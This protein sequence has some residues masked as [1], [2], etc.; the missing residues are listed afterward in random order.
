MNILKKSI[1]FFVAFLVISISTMEAQKFI[2]WSPKIG[3]LASALDTELERQNEMNAETEGRIGWTI[4]FDAR[5]T[6]R[7]LIIHPGIHY[8]Q[9]T[10]ELRSLEEDNLPEILE[11]ETTISMLKAPVAIG[12]YLTGE[13][14]IVRLHVRGGIAAN[15]LLGVT[16][17][18][19]FSVSEE[20]L[21][22]ITLGAQVGAGLDVFFGTLDATY[23]WGLTQFFEDAEGKNNQFTISLGLVF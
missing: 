23:E 3:Y 5:I 6:N 13:K 1:S 8:Q 12:T 4:G 22:N 16:D 19:I 20:D 9:F 15:L 14:S 21:K 7:S 10:A 11:E 2:H 18:D 17:E